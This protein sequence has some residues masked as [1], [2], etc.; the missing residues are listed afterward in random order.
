MNSFEPDP[1]EQIP[2]QLVLL[3]D[4]PAAPTC[5][6]CGTAP[7]PSG[8]YCDECERRR[9]AEV[10]YRDW[11]QKGWSYAIRP[12]ATLEH[13]DRNGYPDAWYDGYQD[14]AAGREKWHLAP[15]R[16]AA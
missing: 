15:A 9:L 12:S 11:Y 1:F 2:G 13:G 6:A 8:L 3:T 5:L 4:P 7:A 16:V 10:A 14:R